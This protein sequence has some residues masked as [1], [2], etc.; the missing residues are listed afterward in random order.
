MT[1][2]PRLVLQSL[3]YLAF[4]GVVAWLSASPRYDYA[5]PAMAQVKISLSHA[6]ERV[7]PC[8]QLTPEEIAE[9]ARNMRRTE[10][11]PRGR[12]PLFLEFAMDGETMLSL[13]SPPTGLWNDGPA[14]VYERFSVAPGK[15]TIA[16]RLRDSARSDGWDYSYEDEVA[17]APGRYFIVTF[18]PETGGFRFR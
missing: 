13:E 6:T 4:A 16:V 14:S 3:A 11:C 5:D 12:L 8:V 18:R 15:H 2:P 1:D 10:S 7:E 17:L 9:L